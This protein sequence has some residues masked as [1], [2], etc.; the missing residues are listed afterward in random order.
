MSA[1]LGPI[2]YWMYNKIRLREELIASLVNLAK[3][4]NYDEDPDGFPLESYARRELPP[5]EEAIDLSR[6]HA[7]LSGQIDGVERRYAKLITGLLRQDPARLA[8]IREC[9]RAFGAAHP[10]SAANPTMAFQGINDVLLDGMPC[11]HA[12]QINEQAEDQ[13]SFSLVEDLHGPFWE[14][15]GGDRDIFYLLRGELVNAMLTVSGY[16]LYSDGDGSY[17]IAQAASLKS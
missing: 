5:I 2:H 3:R 6:I 9:V 7:S 10:V 4:Q 8:S 15:E 12:I 11:D 17:H 1:T 13:V 16:R 14:E